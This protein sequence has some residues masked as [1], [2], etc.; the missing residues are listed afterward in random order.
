[1]RRLSSLSLG[2]I[3]VALLIHAREVAAARPE[4]ASA[5]L[6]TQEDQLLDGSIGGGR[7]LSTPASLVMLSARGVSQLTQHATAAIAALG[8]ELAAPSPARQQEPEQST[9]SAML[10]VTEAGPDET[11]ANPANDRVS[12]GPFGVLND[13]MT[14]VDLDQFGCVAGQDSTS[15]F[16]HFIGGSPVECEPPQPVQGCHRYVIA[17]YSQSCDLAPLK[18]FLRT[19]NTELFQDGVYK[20]CYEAPYLESRQV[21]TKGA[22]G[23]DRCDWE[24][25]ETVAK[26]LLQS[27]TRKLYA[28]SLIVAVLSHVMVPFL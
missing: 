10:D 23:M 4:S 6:Q 19:R 25:C 8:S 9:P 17:R 27:G 3:A 16:V 18:S 13:K 28:T 24:Y 26:A 14:V 2:A 20:E 7:P 12:C 5:H 21:Y 15:V 11:P 1:M 22:P